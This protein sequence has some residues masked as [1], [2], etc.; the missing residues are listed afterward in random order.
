MISEPLPKQRINPVDNSHTNC[1]LIKE[2]RRQP[3]QRFVMKHTVAQ[4]ANLVQCHRD[5]VPLPLR[6]R[7]TRKHKAEVFPEDSLELCVEERTP[8]A[9]GQL[10]QY[11]VRGLRFMSSNQLFLCTAHFLVL[12][13]KG[14]ITYP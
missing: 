1:V 8:E 11:L 2:R 6:L 13:L 3:Q 10:S 12:P 5:V 14:R 4:V 7:T 9:K